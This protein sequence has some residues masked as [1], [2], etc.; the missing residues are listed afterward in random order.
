M[1]SQPIPPAE[2]QLLETDAFAIDLFWER[3]R[4]TILLVAAAVVISVVAVVLWMI[5]SHNSRLAAQA[6]FAKASGT[7]EWQQV[8]EKYPSS[9]QAANAYLLLGAAQ[10]E[11][12]DLEASTTTFQDFLVKFPKSQL[13]GEAWLGLAENLDLE[14]KSAEAIKVLEEIQAGQ[15]DSYVAAYAAFLEGRLAV[16]EGRLEDA[17]KI[18]S[19]LVATYPTSPVARLAG[20]QVDELIPFL[21]PQTTSDAPPPVE[22]KTDG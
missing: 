1:S 13:L 4:T 6:Q 16:R 15:A 19:A 22:P 17:R 18:F 8:I 10:R 9:P 5:N 12:G 21:P 20:A 3:F 11:A 7:E 14:G 2:E